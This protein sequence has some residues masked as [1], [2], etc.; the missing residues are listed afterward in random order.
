M[1]EEDSDLYERFE[2][3]H[4][5]RTFPMA[6]YKSLLNQAGFEVKEVLADFDEEP[7]ETSER[8]FFIAIKK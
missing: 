8:I 6:T 2:E 7:S 4:N 3:Y 5:Q 1:K